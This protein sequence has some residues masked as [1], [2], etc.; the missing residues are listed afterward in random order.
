[1]TVGIT[2]WGDRVSPVLDA[3][4][5]LLVFRTGSVAGG[6]SV[7]DLSGLSFW[8]RAAEIERA[9]ID[10]LI[11][12]AVTR[13]LLDALTGSGLTVVP[14]ISGSVDE[15]LEAFSCG[16]LSNE[17]FAMPGCGR[18]TRACGGD[19]RRGRR[20]GGGAGPRRRRR[21]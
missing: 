15:I 9:G 13:P 4:E 12:G 2:T 14:W 5:R 10:V 21:E 6:T 18:P 8:G 16:E 20:R 7:V 11:C 1:M 3:A 17:R 19:P